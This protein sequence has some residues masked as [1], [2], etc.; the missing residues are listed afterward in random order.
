MKKETQFTS[1]TN[2]AEECMYIFYISYCC[3][4]RLETA[5]RQLASQETDAQEDG[6]LYLNESE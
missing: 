6:R 3:P 4:D 2:I 1:I 5:N